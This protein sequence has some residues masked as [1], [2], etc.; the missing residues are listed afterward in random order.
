M[1]RYVNRI[2]SN[3]QRSL[4]TKKNIFKQMNISNVL[5]YKRSFPHIYLNCCR[6]WV[7]QCVL[8]HMFFSCC[9][10]MLFIWL[11]LVSVVALGPVLLMHNFTL[12]RTDS[13]VEARGLRSPRAAL[14]VLPVGLSDAPLSWMLGPGGRLLSWVLLQELLADLEDED[15]EPSQP[16]VQCCSP[17]V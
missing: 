12:W 14:L 6:Y 10:F 9:L 5:F 17:V 4:L 3:A 7:C 2:L 13:L 16:Q 1:T 11:H 8:K 15:E